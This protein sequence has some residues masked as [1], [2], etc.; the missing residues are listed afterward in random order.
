M[1]GLLERL[2]QTTREAFLSAITDRGR[3]YDLILSLVAWKAFSTGADRAAWLYSST[4]ISPDPSHEFDQVMRQTGESSHKEKVLGAL[5]AWEN[6]N[7]GELSD[8]LAVDAELIRDIP[9]F[10][11]H[12]I[13]QSWT[14]FFIGQHDENIPLRELMI[15]VMDELERSMSDERLIFENYAPKELVGLMVNLL[16]GKQGKSLY[17]PYSWS[18]A[19]L[20]AGAQQLPGLVRVEGFSVAALPW[21]LAKL[22]LLLLS[23]PAEILMEKGLNYYKL[24]GEQKFDLIMANPPYG[25]WETPNLLSAE[26]GSWS[27]LAAS[28]HR[29]DLSMACHCLDR[30]SASGSASVLLPG[31]F[32]SGQGALHE[33]RRRVMQ[34]NLLETVVTLPAGVFPQTGV[35]T[36]ILLFNKKKRDDKVLMLDATALLQNSTT[37]VRLDE[38]AINEYLN[39]YRN[40]T[41]VPDGRCLLVTNSEIAMKRFDLKFSSYIRADQFLV[42]PYLPSATLLEACNRLSEDYRRIEKRVK[43]LIDNK[44]ANRT[45]EN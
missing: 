25:R 45:G 34:H 12:Y 44:K 4:L 28:S 41:V 11:W 2:I 19:F 32:L 22:R 38:T 13:S 27:S 26:P 18:G 39:R 24:P 9:S 15:S 1:K 16:N 8:L 30:L 7:V 37:E 31:I 42:N 29:I 3:F 33:F 10:T 35:S 40:G 20:S 43:E 36:T 17:D 5:R 14:A 23:I 6:A 21:K